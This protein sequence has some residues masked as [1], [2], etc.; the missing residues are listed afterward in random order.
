MTFV[1]HIV[2]LAAVSLGPPPLMHAQTTIGTLSC[3]STTGATLSPT[4]YF[5][6]ETTYTDGVRVNLAFFYTDP[7]Q[8]APLLAA[9][10]A[11]TSY[12]CTYPNDRVNISFTGAVISEVGA[13]AYGALTQG[14]AYPVAYVNAMATFDTLTAGGVTTGGSPLTP[15]KIPAEIKAKAFADSKARVAIQLAQKPAP[16]ATPSLI[17]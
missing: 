16:V 2:T 4:V 14:F 7:A 12:T 10:N 13:D 5:D 11:Q 1:R 17:K 8:L 6:V 3:T 15:A 9:Q